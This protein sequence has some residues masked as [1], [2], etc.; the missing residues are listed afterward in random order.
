[1]TLLKSTFVI[2]ITRCGKEICFPAWEDTIGPLSKRK[3]AEKLLP[4]ICM[5]PN[6]RSITIVEERTEQ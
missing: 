6:V 1:M 3:L 2:K 5:N 4:T